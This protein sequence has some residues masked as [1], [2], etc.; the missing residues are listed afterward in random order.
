MKKTKDKTMKDITKNFKEFEKK[1][2][3][4]EA[5][6]ESFDKVVKIV[7]KGKSKENKAKE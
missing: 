7:I 3:L 4:K 5:N 6:K 2:E 1:H